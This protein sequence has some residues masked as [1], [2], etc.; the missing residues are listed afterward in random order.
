MFDAIA[1]RYDTLNHTLSL[2]LDR[3]WRRRA[4]RELHLSGRERV[5]DVCTGT[6]DLAF[7][8]LTSTAGSARDVV[9]IDFA[10][11]MLRRA[12]AKA[13]R[14]GLSDRVLF[15]R[16][17]AMGL[18]CPDASSDAVTVAFGIRNVLDPE[19]ACR[20][21]FRVLRPGGQLAVLEFGMPSIPGIRTAYR[22]YFRYLLPR[23]GGMVSRHGE[24]YSYLPASVQQFATPEEFAAM[25]ERVGF[26]SVRSVRLTLGI[27]YLH[28]AARP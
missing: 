5:F 27:V 1:R 17:D 20:E 15:V 2:G 12:H 13:A 19:A 11:E 4:I 28:V 16:G 6:G 25:L 10:G 24:A 23:V 21:F 22:W 8:A 3:R 18:P 7:E 26:Q 9:G 14:A